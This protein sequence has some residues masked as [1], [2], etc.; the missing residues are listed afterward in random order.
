MAAKPEAVMLFAAGLGTRMGPLTAYQP[1]PLI[2]VAGRTLLDHA[3][4][5]VGTTGRIVINLHYLPDLI[6]KHLSPRRDILFSDETETILETGGGLRK[7]LPLLAANPVF[8]M[9]TDA[10]WTGEN[11]ISQLANAWDPA[12]MDALLL[13]V[14]R[15]RATGHR[16]TGD[17]QIAPD[18]TLTRGPGLVYTGAQII[19]TDGLTDIAEP[20]FSLNSLWD[21]M[22]ANGTLHGVSHTGGWCD[23][24]RPESIPLAEA[25]LNEA[26]DV[27]TR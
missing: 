9:N 23:V 11:A 20:V 12:R 25:L 24:G 2:K 5:Q 16:G 26:I 19:K 8:T 18:G 10:V 7:A 15:E 17:F 27:R 22:A 1:K 3:L 21:R 4:D 6:R 14:P 13:L